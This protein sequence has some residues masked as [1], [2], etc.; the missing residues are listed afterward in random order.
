MG[1]FSGTLVHLGYF[2]DERWQHFLEHFLWFEDLG[3]GIDTSRIHF[4]EHFEEEMRAHVENAHRAMSALEAGAIANPDENRQVGHYW[5]RNPSLAPNPEIQNEISTVHGDVEDFVRGV[6]MGE[7]SGDG[8]MFQH[9]LCIGI[10]GSA[11][12]TKFVAHALKNL[13]KRHVLELHFLDNTDPDGI[14]QELEILKGAL[15]KTLVLVISKSGTTPETRNGMLE[16]MK[17]YEQEGIA[18]SR[19]AVAIT[20]RGSS[21]DQ[22]ARREGWLHVFPMWDWVG[23]R[24]SVMSV[25]GLLPLALLGMDTKGLL[26]GARAMDTLTRGAGK[27]NPAM[28][29]ALAWYSATNGKGEKAMVVIPYKDRLSLLTAYLQQL[30]MESLGKRTDFDGNFVRQGLTV[31]GNKG[32]TDQHSYVQQLR[33]GLQNFF[34]TFVEVLKDREVAE[35][36]AILPIATGD[37]LE[38][39]LLGTRE[40]LTEEACDSI[41]IT[42]REVNAASVGMLMALYERAVGFYAQFIRINA[43]H[44]PGVEAGK[45]AAQSLLDAQASLGEIFEQY[46]TPLS[47]REIVELLRKH[48]VCLAPDMVFKLLE[49]LVANGRL[50]AER[51]AHMHD[52]RYFKNT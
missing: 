52:N 33:D 14:D 32:S 12:G 26:A 48:E 23:G 13:P 20:C 50:N 7:F 31:Y 9:L 38:G 37:Y 51:H 25:V 8:G 36:K 41:T 27:E 29:L 2:M 19:H 18:F 10:G 49:H 42:L 21:L 30:I 5:L 24:T 16:T 1:M 4:H 28:R 15:G 6:H 40:A 22:Q 34:V 3:F 45:K 43:Y 17:A 46:E 35:T 44:Q 39:F 47:I 11:L